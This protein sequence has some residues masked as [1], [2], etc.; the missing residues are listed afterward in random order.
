MSP[1]NRPPVRV[2]PI[3][4]NAADAQIRAGAEKRTIRRLI[5]YCGL[6]N[7]RFNKGGA[8]D[9]TSFLKK[10]FHHSETRY[11][12]QIR[13]TASEYRRLHPN[14]YATATAIATAIATTLATTCIH[15]IP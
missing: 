3:R 11:R 4:A 8:T 7:F 10:V 9:T 13:F 2:N 5:T 12:K 15:S 14:P 1:T 6:S